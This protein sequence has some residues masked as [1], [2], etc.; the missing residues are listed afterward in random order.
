MAT[1][2]FKSFNHTQIPSISKPVIH[3]PLKTQLKFPKTQSKS[4]LY[5]TNN[6]Q[7]QEPINPDPHTNGSPENGGDGSGDEENDLKAN[8]KNLLFNVKLGDL[9]LDPD[10]DNIL[11]VGLTGILAWASAQVL[12]QLFIVSF[13]IL[14]AALKYSFIAAF[15][16]FILITLL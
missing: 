9:F 1:L 12:W 15:L 10:P 6:D 11:A 2:G 4:L 8:R 13:V 14:T 7:I 16:V 3:L 5:A